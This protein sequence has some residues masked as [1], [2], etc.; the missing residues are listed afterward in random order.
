MILY[1]RPNKCS[2]VSKLIKASFLFTLIPL[3]LLNKMD[4]SLRL[5]Q[6]SSIWAQLYLTRVPR[7]RYSPDSTEDSS[8][9]KIKPCLE[10]QEHLNKFRDTTD[11]LPCH[12]HLPVS[13]RI[14]DPH[15]RAAKKNTSHGNEVLAQ[16][17]YVSLT[18]TMLPVKKS[19]PRSNRQSDHTKT[20]WPS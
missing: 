11:V 19:V 15:S 4:R 14:M 2:V 17:N 20:S 12:I 1:C 10:W 5:S 8:I 16:D 6:A 18:K 13:M 3:I 7:L 9:D